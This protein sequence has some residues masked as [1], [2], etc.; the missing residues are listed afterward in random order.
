MAGNIERAV[1]YVGEMSLMESIVAIVSVPRIRAE[2]RFLPVIDSRGQSRRDLAAAAHASIASA[3]NL[4]P[5][6]S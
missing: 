1:A 3:L 2:V 4:P 6:D 5:A